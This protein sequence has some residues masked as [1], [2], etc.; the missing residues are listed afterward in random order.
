MHAVGLLGVRVGLAVTRRLLDCCVSQ[1]EVLAAVGEV[2]ITDLLVEIFTCR[3]AGRCL[4]QSKL[5]GAVRNA[6][7]FRLITQRS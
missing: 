1:S 3:C 7:W 6:M 4:H 5:A 2:P